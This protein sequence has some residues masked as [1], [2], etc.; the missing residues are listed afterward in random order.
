MPEVRL[1]LLVV[2]V[3]LLSTAC[4]ESDQVLVELS[5]GDHRWTVVGTCSTA[6]GRLSVR[7][8]EPAASADDDAIEIRIDDDE[9]WFSLSPE[10]LYEITALTALADGTYEL[11]T[12]AAQAIGQFTFTL[13]CP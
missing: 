3:A 10:S 2:A 9:G 6:D 5:D 7:A 1:L 12:T 11:E 8:G 4:S 13:R